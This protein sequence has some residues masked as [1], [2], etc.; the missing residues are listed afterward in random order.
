MK[1]SLALLI[2]LLLGIGREFLKLPSLAS[3]TKHMPTL[4]EPFQ[5]GHFSHL[6]H[7]P[8]TTLFH[9]NGRV[10]CGT[11]SRGYDNHVGRLLGLDADGYG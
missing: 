4:E 8:C 11:G 1:H 2:A 3:A 10:G 6:P 7:K 9:R 5:G